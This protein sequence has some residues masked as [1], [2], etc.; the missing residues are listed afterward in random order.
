MVTL[1]LRLKMIDSEGVT[2]LKV[3]VKFHHSE[4]ILNDEMA[5]GAEHSSHNHHFR[6]PAGSGKAILHQLMC[7]TSLEGFLHGLKGSF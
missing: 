5:R 4:F 7:S 2:D 3:N 1:G 6:F